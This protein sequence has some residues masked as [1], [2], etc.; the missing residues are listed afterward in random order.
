[1]TRMITAMFDSRAEADSAADALVRD[2]ALSRS[3]VQ[4]HGG[5]TTTRTPASSSAATTSD[6]DL[7]SRGFWGSLR[8]L[9]V[10]DEDRSTYA[11][12][13]RRGGVV[14][15]AEIDDSRMEQAMDVLEAHGAVD[16]DSRES[17]WRQSGWTGSSTSTTSSTGTG[18][19]G[20]T[21]T[22]GTA[23]EV[24]VA[25]TTREGMTARPGGAGGDFT[26]SP[27]P[28]SMDRTTASSAMR[29]STT[30]TTTATGT[31]GSAHRAATGQE[32]VIPVVEERVQIGKRDVERGR[33]RV[34][35]Y[36]VETPVHE[37]VTLR[38]ETVDVQRRPVDRAAK[39][40][41]DLFRERTIEAVEHGE[42]PV[43]AKEARVTEEVVLRKDKTERTE[44][45]DD[46]VRRTKVEVEDSS[47]K[48]RMMDGSGAKASASNTSASNTS[49]SAPDGT[50]GNPKG[51]AAS[52][53]ID[54]T[55]GTNISGRD[56]TTR[57]P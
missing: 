41:D 46:T 15:S 44:K 48:K 1:M 12:G 10:P 36:I 50:P 6:A 56:Q 20:K 43:V 17:Q 22:L 54:D 33:V 24:G 23:P 42:E 34:R 21:A 49:A 45:V 38:S 13:I 27:A 7:E 18:T 52:R 14:V 32:E 53:A 4:V 31:M 30:A 35:S 47:G 37:Q 19:T 40:G 28:G 11:E 39:P 2:L 25:G 5:D 9:F 16:L 26:T 8:D 55:L 3:A 29:G 57:K 51:T